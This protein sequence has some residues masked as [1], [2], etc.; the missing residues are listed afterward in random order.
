MDKQTKQQ[1]RQSV[2][3]NIEEERR[4]RV[5]QDPFAQ[6][7]P[8]ESAQNTRVKGPAYPSATSHSNAGYQP[9][10]LTSQPHVPHW[11]NEVYNLHGLGTRPLDPGTSGAGIWYGLDPS[12]MP[13][14]YKT[15]V[16]QTNLAE[17]H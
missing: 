6:P 10:G 5:S 8:Y 15:P 4:R 13:N 17:A 9:T 1:P 14:L 12:Q 11:N 3:Y 2:A 16:P 7:R